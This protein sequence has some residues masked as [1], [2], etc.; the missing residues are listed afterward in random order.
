MTRY[1][2]DLN[3][4]EERPLSKGMGFRWTTL[5]RVGWVARKESNFPFC[6]TA[7]HATGRMV[8]VSAASK[9]EATTRSV[10]SCLNI[11]VLG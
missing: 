6:I 2:S 10:I 4:T 8:T 7:D 5:V 1:L 3:S 9:G 11:D